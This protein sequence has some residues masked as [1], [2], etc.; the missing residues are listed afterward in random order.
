[1]KA[2]AVAALILAIALIA[3]GLLSSPRYALQRMS[4]TTAIKLDRWT[5]DIVLCGHW[6]DE[7]FSCW[8]AEEWSYEPPSAKNSN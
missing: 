6:K 3:F 1:M 8:P 7:S 5:G 2:N 4:E